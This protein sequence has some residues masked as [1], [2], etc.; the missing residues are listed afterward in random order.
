VRYSTPE[1]GGAEYIAVCQPAF[2]MNTVHR[3]D[4]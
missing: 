2:S 1:A 4:E 3:D